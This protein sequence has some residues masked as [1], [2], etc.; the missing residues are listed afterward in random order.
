[1]YVH[2][3]FALQSAIMLAMQDTKLRRSRRMAWS[4]Q[5]GSYILAPGGQVSYMEA[6]QK[7]QKPS[8]PAWPPK[9]NSS[10]RKG[11]HTENTAKAKGRQAGGQ[12]TRGKPEQVCYERSLGT[13]Q[14]REQN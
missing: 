14:G 11:E 10:W 12:S 9:Q 2:V 5:P 1:M 6:D 13:T 7:P 3:M 4:C 8:W